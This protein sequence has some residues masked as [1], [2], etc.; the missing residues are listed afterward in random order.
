MCDI[1]G[2]IKKCHEGCCELY[3]CDLFY[4]HALPSNHIMIPM[5]PDHVTHIQIRRVGNVTFTN[6]PSSLISFRCV[7]TNII[8]LP[9]LP[10][11][12]QY[13]TI[14]DNYRMKKCPELPS[15]LRGLSC[16]GVIRGDLFS[17]RRVFGRAFFSVDY[18][19]VDREERSCDS[20][21]KRE[22]TSMLSNGKEK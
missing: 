9:E 6:L 11:Y 10:K 8:T 14:H 12:L 4:M 5:I 18:A 19:W 7:D 17:E 2:Q 15:R 3:L 20:P 16:Y 22:I 1:N 13:L 21:T